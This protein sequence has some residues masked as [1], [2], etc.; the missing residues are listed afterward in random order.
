MLVVAPDVVHVW[1]VS[2]DVAPE[3]EA[4]LDDGERDRAARFKF[5]ATRRLFMAAHGALRLLL[6]RYL[7][8]DPRT[9]RFET[10]PDGKPFVDA[11]IEF[12]LSHSD[13]L[14]VVAIGLPGRPVGV[15]VERRR[16]LTSREGIARRIMTP[17]ELV[18]YRRAGEE[19]RDDFLLWVWARKEA[20][21][22]ASGRGVREPLTELPCEPGEDSPWSVVDLDVPGYAAAVAGSGRG[23]RPQLRDLDG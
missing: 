12:N 2:A 22:K 1:R 6:G 23:W 5:D 19:E 13:E 16:R 3:V 10:E 20:L 8:V 4:L 7:D 17:D 11:P 15:D 14:A 21:V 9:L 18:R